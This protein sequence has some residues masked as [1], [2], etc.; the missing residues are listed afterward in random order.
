MGHLKIGFDDKKDLHCSATDNQPYMQWRI[1]L[2]K[3]YKMRLT[4][5]K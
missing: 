3:D 1:H 4:F 2:I 5:F